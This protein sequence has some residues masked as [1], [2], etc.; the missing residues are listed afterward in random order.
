MKNVLD[1]MK[2]PIIQGG[3]GVGI[4]LG[5]LAGHV[6]REGGMGVIAAAAIGF[7]E[8]DFYQHPLE[9][10]ERA[11]KKEVEKAKEIAQGNGL[12]AINIMTASNDYEAMARA[13]AKSGCDA[14]ISGAGLPLSLPDYVP[15]DGPMIA[16]IVSSGRAAK[17]IMKDWLR[18]HNR[19]PDFLVVEGSE[20]GGHLGFK[21]EELKNH[22]AKTLEENV[23]DV[24]KEAGDIP[25]FAAG[26]V[27]DKND[28][29]KMLDL[30]AAGVQVGTRFALS[31][32]GDATQGFKDVLLNATED[33][34]RII[35]SPVGMPGRAII[36]PLIETVESGDRVPPTRCIRCI[37]ICNP[38][39]TKYCISNALIKAYYGNYEEGLFFTGSNVGRINKMLTVKEIMDE[40]NPNA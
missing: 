33:D 7:R 19:V 26:G 37:R 38:A 13:A 10:G 1:H 17:I 34:V 32:E 2:L 21:P 8:P 20:A 30:G 14:I 22:T 5:N 28:V 12:V 27:F 15:E 24:L 29:K 6:A 3:M 16:P 39:T 25:V 31:V 35:T 40:L 23:K 4:S 9:A 36:T 11:M 18:H